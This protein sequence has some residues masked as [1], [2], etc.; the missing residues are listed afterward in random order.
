MKIKIGNFNFI[1]KGPNNLYLGSNFLYNDKLDNFYMEGKEDT[2][3]VR[4]RS[5][6]NKADE[7]NLEFEKE[8]LRNHYIV[9]YTSLIKNQI[10]QF[11][12]QKAMGLLRR[13]DYSRYKLYNEIFLNDIT[14]YE[15]RTKFNDYYIQKITENNKLVYE[16]DGNK[17]II[18][19]PYADKIENLEELYK[20]GF[21]DRII[22]F[23]LIKLEVENKIA[24]LFV[25]EVLKI[26]DFIKNKK[27]VTLTF[28]DDEKIKIN[29]KIDNILYKYKNNFN[30]NTTYRNYELKDLKSINF[31]NTEIRIDTNAFVNLPNQIARFAMDVLYFRIDEMKEEL[32]E[33][34]TDFEKE[35]NREIPTDIRNCISV[36]AELNNKE[37]LHYYEYSKSENIKYPKWFN[38][39]FIYLWK[40]YEM[41][42]ELENAKDL[43][44]IKEVA[45]LTGDKEIEKVFY[46]LQEEC[47]EEEEDW[48]YIPVEDNEEESE[49]M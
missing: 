15:D 40:Q 37:N 11:I 7:L 43:E 36:I 12:K 28:K 33:D 44:D 31:G 42:L 38:D 22:R 46:M 29:A 39:D 6:F 5:T 32:R 9:E 10:E 41:I 26:N 49:E 34:F 23:Y 18:F 19:D 35:M 48:T 47:Y 27:T 20:A 14:N 30:L 8:L 4:D 3:Y 21:F 1:S 2:I 45:V 17:Q 24:P 25:H 16:F 13:E